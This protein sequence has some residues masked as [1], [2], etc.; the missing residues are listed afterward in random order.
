MRVFVAGA[1]G[2]LGRRIVDE[3]TDRG[4]DVVCLVR[5]DAGATA[6]RERGGEPVRGDVLDADGLRE[7]IVGVAPDAVVNAAT[8]IPTATRPDEEAWEQNDRVRREGARNLVEA[9]GAAEADR[10]LQQSVVWVA[11]QPDGGA[12]DEGAEPHPD[13]TTQSALDAERIVAEAAEHHGFDPVIL[14][15]GWFYAADAAHTRQFAERLLTGWLPVI[16]AGLLGRSDATLSYVHADDA[17]AAYAAAIE[18]D[19]T[20]TFHVVDD[21]PA[22]FS[23]FVRG[24]AD[25]LDA[26]EPGRIPAW[27]ARLF[28]GKHSARMLSKSM[29]T[30]NDRFR[31]AFD[32]EPRYDTYREGLDAVV[33]RWRADGTIRETGEGY[34]WAG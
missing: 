8:T 12:F 10:F 15:G 24:L 26:G 19:A 9:A 32:W 20:G 7:A 29:P 3:C 27:I 11:R 6:V 25:R 4:H 1:T 17:G 13:R 28:V 14:R 2:V 33:E 31:E 22:P 23:A 5:D 34:E 16:G 18:G 21:E 30:T